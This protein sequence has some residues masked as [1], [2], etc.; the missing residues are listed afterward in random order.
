MLLPEVNVNSFNINAK[1][2]ISS[3]VMLLL[4]FENILLSCYPIAVNDISV[5]LSFILT[6]VSQLA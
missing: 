2:C 6:L 1:S 3:K 4:E 5:R